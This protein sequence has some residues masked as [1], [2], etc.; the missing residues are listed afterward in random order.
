ME[1]Q[2]AAF[3]GLNAR[4]H[5]MSDLYVGAEEAERDAFA[6]V[7]WLAAFQRFTLRS[8]PSLAGLPCPP[9]RVPTFCRG[10]LRSKRREGGA[11]RRAGNLH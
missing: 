10:W 7:P 9:S 2:R 1:E 3:L 11:Q 5:Q 8:A 4:L 6:T